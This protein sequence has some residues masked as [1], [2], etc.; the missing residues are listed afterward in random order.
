MRERKALLKT[1]NTCVGGIV[2]KPT[3]DCKGDGQLPYKVMVVTGQDK[4]E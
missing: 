2:V 1:L 3:I 4:I